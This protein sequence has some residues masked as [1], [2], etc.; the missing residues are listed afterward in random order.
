M[1]GRKSG[2]YPRFCWFNSDR[3]TFFN[4]PVKIF[5]VYIINIYLVE[6]PWSFLIY[7]LLYFIPLYTYFLIIGGN[8]FFFKRSTF[9]NYHS[10]VYNVLKV[11][12]FIFTLFYSL[13]LLLSIPAAVLWYSHTL[14]TSFNLK[15]LF[16]QLTWLFY[17]KFFVLSYI[18]LNTQSALDLLL[19]LLLLSFWFFFLYSSNNIFTFVFCLEILTLLVFVLGIIFITLSSLKTKVLNPSSGKSKPFYNIIFI[20]IFFWVSTIISI[21]LFV[22][23]LL[24]SVYFFSF[25]WSLIDPLLYLFIYFNFNNNFCILNLIFFFLLIIIF[26][27]MGLPPF[28]IWKIVF[29]LNIPLY[30]LLV[31]ITYFYFFLFIF[32]IFFI[33]FLN[34]SI[35][36]IF[37]TVFNLLLLVNLTLILFNLVYSVFLKFFFVISSALNSVLILFIL[38]TNLS[39]LYSVFY[40]LSLVLNFF[41]CYNLALIYLLFIILV[42]LKSQIT[43]MNSFKFLNFNS[44]TIVFLIFLVLAGIPPVSTFFLKLSLISIIIVFNNTVWLFFISFF[45]LAIYFY[46]N[47]TKHILYIFNFKKLHTIS[48]LTLFKLTLNYKVYHILA[49]LLGFFT[50][51]DFF[52]L[53]SSALY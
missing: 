5:I 10:Y 36:S 21:S 35:F 2:S 48:N 3:F 32:F 40:S 52:I 37:F 7:A 28:F 41:I 25:E 50:L 8:F 49:L 1:R 13:Y 29:F 34:V 23:L 6:L 26:F 45:F 46:Y 24:F 51:T 15:F 19:L 33:N 18:K 30:Y 16:F 31:Y 22:F 9:L 14:V 42:N 44:Q 4:H 39:S 20:F 47:N 38:N 43:Y 11:V 27:K 17:L 53:V 12:F